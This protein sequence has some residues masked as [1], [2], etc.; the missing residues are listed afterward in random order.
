MVLPILLLSG[1]GLGVYAITKQEKKGGKEP[2]PQVKKP[3]ETVASDPDFAKLVQKYNGVRI[4]DVPKEDLQLLKDHAE[5][6]IRLGRIGTMIISTDHRNIP[7][8]LRKKAYE[9]ER[10]LARLLATFSEPDIIL[11]AVPIKGQKD[12]GFLGTGINLK[13]LARF[14]TNTAAKVVSPVSGDTVS[15]TTGEIETVEGRNDYQV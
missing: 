9:S 15:K 12:W 8:L 1:L 13:K 6:N 3:I 5:A 2:P 14:T 7:W 10:D 11:H 4:R